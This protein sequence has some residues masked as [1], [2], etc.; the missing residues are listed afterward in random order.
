MDTAVAPNAHQ[1]VSDSQTNLKTATDKLEVLS[2]MFENLP[3]ITH[4]NHT[5]DLCWISLDSLIKKANIDLL[6]MHRYLNIIISMLDKPESKEA[7]Q[8]ALQIVKMTMTKINMKLQSSDVSIYV[9]QSIQ[10]PRRADK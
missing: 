5:Y 2:Q 10:H 9:L 6:M 4:T 3:G 1:I 8:E 7:L